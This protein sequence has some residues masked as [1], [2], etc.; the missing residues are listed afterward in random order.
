MTI[1]T[2][3]YHQR[4]GQVLYNALAAVYGQRYGYTPEIVGNY[5]FPVEPENEV[6]RNDA[7]IAIRQLGSILQIPGQAMSSVERGT[8]SR[9]A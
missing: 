8:P 7:E 1:V 5:S 4:W 3:S 6:Y 2:S 9:A